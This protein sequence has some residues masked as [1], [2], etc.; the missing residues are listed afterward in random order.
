[1]QGKKG[2]LH[3]CTHLNRWEHLYNVNFLLQFFDFLGEAF[4]CSQDLF[5]RASG[6]F[7]N[8]LLSFAS[9]LPY[10]PSAP[11]SHKMRDNRFLSQYT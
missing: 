10:G 11:S 6:R 5:G 1:M 2:T 3:E 8:R 4:H 9:Y 7:I